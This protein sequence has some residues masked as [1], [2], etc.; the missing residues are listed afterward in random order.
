VAAAQVLVC[1]AVWEEARYFIPSAGPAT[2]TRVTGIGIQKAAAAIQDALATQHP[3]LVLTCGFAGGLNPVHPVGRVLFDDALAGSFRNR[4][5]PSGAVAG[6]FTH[7]DRILVAAAEKRQLFETS[8][9]DAVEM[10]SSAIVAACRER[11]LPVMVV[12]VISDAATEDLPLDFNRFTR[13]DGS[14]SM[15][16]LL[17]GIA[18]SPAAVPKLIAFQRRLDLAARNL[19]ATLASLLSS[20]DLA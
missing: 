4:L 6:R 13:S 1:F 12:R 14:L 15:P 3:A 5:I 16:Q 11:G 19:A 8:G 10:E 2:L 17:L 7:S 9:A 18:K 20:D